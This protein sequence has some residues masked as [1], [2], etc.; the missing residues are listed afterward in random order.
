M[1]ENPLGCYGVTRKDDRGGLEGMV[2]AIFEDETGGQASVL[3]TKT[4]RQKR[5]QDGDLRHR[6][7]VPPSNRRPAELP[8][9]SGV[10]FSPRSWLPA[11][12]FVAGQPIARR[13]RHGSIWADRYLHAVGSA[14]RVMPC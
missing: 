8:P 12:W 14:S 10:R 11:R 4:S 6:L 9:V 3:S 5:R 1:L 13:D 7:A 2:M